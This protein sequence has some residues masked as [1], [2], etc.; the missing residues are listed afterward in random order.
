M[1]LLRAW[2]CV[3][4]RQQRTV[5]NAT[6]MSHDSRSHNWPADTLCWATVVLK[7]GAGGGYIILSTAAFCW[8]ILSFDG[9]NLTNLCFFDFQ[10]AADCFRQPKEDRVVLMIK[11][12]WLV[13]QLCVVFVG[14]PV[15]DNA[16]FPSSP[17]HSMQAQP[18]F[19][20]Q[21]MQV[22]NPQFGIGMKAL[23]CF[24]KHCQVATEA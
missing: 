22:M 5:C 23:W 6:L 9:N 2:S 10:A 1:L 3:V 4:R 16:F 18:H 7:S 17:L 14:D 20:E 11:T 24:V 19:S 15:H 8:L 12:H 13:S 21:P